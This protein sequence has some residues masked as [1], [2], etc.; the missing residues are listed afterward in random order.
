MQKYRMLRHDY[1]MKFVKKCRL[2]DC[3]IFFIRL[4]FNKKY[5]IFRLG[6]DKFLYFCN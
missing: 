4:G 6:F 1:V 2:S 3:L 5:E